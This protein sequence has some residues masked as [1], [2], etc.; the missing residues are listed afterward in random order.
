MLEIK[1]LHVEVNGEKIIRGLDLKLEGGGIYALMGPN[2]SGKSTLAN[3]I[4]GNPKYNITKGKI[5]FK[6]KDI[7]KFSPTARAKMGIFLSFQNPPE[8]FG[9]KFFSFLKTANNSLNKKK[10]SV[11]D[12]KNLL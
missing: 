4:M 12:F 5:I 6:G 9:V 3:V 2:G 7:T 10:I 8:I 1:N 11:I